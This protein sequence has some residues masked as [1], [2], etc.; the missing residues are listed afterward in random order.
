MSSKQ[1]MAAYR[2][3]LKAAGIKRNRGPKK[4]GLY[5]RMDDDIAADL[6]RFATEIKSS[7]PEAVRVMLE[8]GLSEWKAQR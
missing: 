3:R 6:D 4:R 5:L 7:R 2:A 1:R 8:E